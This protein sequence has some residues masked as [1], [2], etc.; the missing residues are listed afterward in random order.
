MRALPLTLGTVLV[1]SGLLACGRVKMPANWGSG[2]DASIN[3]DGSG[4]FDMPLVVDLA[5]PDLQGPCAQC[6]LNATCNEATMPNP[7]TCKNGFVGDGKTCTDIDECT[8]AADDCDTEANCQN[9][10]GGFTCACKPGFRATGTMMGKAGECK[11]NWLPKVIVDETPDGGVAADMGSI[12]AATAANTQPAASGTVVGSG[13]KIYL[14]PYPSGCPSASFFWRSFDVTTGKLDTELKAPID[15]YVCS[16]FQSIQYYTTRP[17]VHSNGQIYIISLYAYLYFDPGSKTFTLDNGTIWSGTTLE[18]GGQMSTR[19]IAQVGDVL[20]FLGGADNGGNYLDL[21]H[22]VPLVPGTGG[23]TTLTPKLPFPIGNMVA[24]SAGNDIYLLFGDKNGSPTTNN[25]LIR[26]ATMGSGAYTPANETD[27]LAAPAL[28]VP[29]N[30]DIYALKNKGGV[31]YQDKLW[32][33]ARDYVSGTGD[34]LRLWNFDPLTTSWNLGLLLPVSLGN[35]EN[36]VR[37]AATTG[38]GARLF[39]LGKGTSALEIY[40]YNE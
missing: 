16:L 32:F 11:Q 29:N 10:I 26:Y 9:T 2:L 5:G 12:P 25:K 8:L 35:N 36:N 3:L 7:C 13:S 14:A 39:L 21:T 33:V 4:S 38:S 15:D 17:R 1:A 40:Q 30:I 20:Y 28:A 31:N 34:V 22:S 23:A 24:V 27:W 18:M 37:L 6:S 19:A